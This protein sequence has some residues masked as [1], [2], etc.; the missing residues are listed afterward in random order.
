V[1]VLVTGSSGL[2]GSA[3]V[4]SLEVE[5]HQV[6]RLVRRPPA[7]PQ[8]VSWDPGKG[9]I[10]AAAL[11]GHDAAV[12]LAGANIGDHRWTD[13]YKARILDSRLEG[14]GLLARTLG[15]LD[16]P[17]K[18]LASGSAIGFYGDRGDEE[19]TEASS[20]GTGFL[21]EVVQA[22][23]TAAGPARE[24]GIRV[25]YLRTGVVQSAEG[26][27]LG[28]QLL[29]FKLALGGRIGS[30]RQW[31]SWIEMTDQV[32][33]ISHVLEHDSLDGPVNL[34]APN[35]VTSAEYAKT[36][37]RVLHRPTVLPIPTPAL[38]LMLGRQ[39]VSEMLLGGQRVLPAALESSG[40]AFANPHLE[41][42]LA[43]AI[44][45]SSPTA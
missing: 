32:R 36:L 43:A 18:V 16:R 40:Y 3:L 39:L 37:G 34:T 33:A 6:T 1:R 7:R 14:T 19:L 25:A 10:D 15:S 41:A 26:G 11:E 28:R 23:E 4:R 17:P 8:E 5:G 21:A 42:A 13:E 20:P 29:P 38:Q 24:A 22:W 27:A 2:I 9:S 31:L 35:P 12:H 45:R 30:G 44:G